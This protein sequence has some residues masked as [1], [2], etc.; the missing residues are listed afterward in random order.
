M[1]PLR[2]DLTNEKEFAAAQV[3]HPLDDAQP[4]EAFAPAESVMSR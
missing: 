2:L 4:V 1:T 3:R